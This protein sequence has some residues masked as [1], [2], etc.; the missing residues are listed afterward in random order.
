MLKICKSYENYKFDIISI[1]LMFANQSSLLSFPPCLQPLGER[2][3]YRKVAVMQLE[4]R[5]PPEIITL[6]RF[7]SIMNLNSK[8]S[9]TPGVSSARE[10]LRLVEFP[11]LKKR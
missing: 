2:K 1:L 8:K 6:E 11:R 4:R 10:Q 9:L 7:N 5:R 3:I